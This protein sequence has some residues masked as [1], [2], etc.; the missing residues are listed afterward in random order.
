MNSLDL[1]ALSGRFDRF[2]RFDSFTDLSAAQ[3]QLVIDR[4]DKT[5]ALLPVLK[6]QAHE[7]I[8]GG[9]RF[10][11]KDKILSNHEPSTNVIVR[12]KSGAEV[13]F[14]N[15]LL[16]GENREGLIVHWELFED[17]RN[18]NKLL[19]AAVA[20]TEKTIG[21]LLD[22]ICGDRGFSDEKMEGEL[23]KNHPGLQN[24]I[25]PKSPARLREKLEDPDFAA[26]QK[27]RAQTEARIGI[28]TNNYQPGRSL[29]KGLDSR[30]QELRWIMLAHNLRV[31]ARKRLREQAAREA[32]QKKNRRAR[33]APPKKAA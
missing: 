7:R 31:L 28:I 13:E 1:Q 25:T 19:P 5:L 2:D 27:R 32:S 9:R 23:I 30:R 33:K 15:P 20:K 29:S 24:H 18:D 12:G 6:K 17:V 21:G 14:G 8:I 3:A 10:P 16:I 26:S 4:I 11:A 22:L